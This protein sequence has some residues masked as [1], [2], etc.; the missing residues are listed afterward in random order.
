MDR[1]LGGARTRL[2]GDNRLLEDLLS[3][4][5]DKQRRLSDDMTAAGLAKQAAE[6]AARQAQELL[7]YVQESE[8][9]ERIGFKKKLSQEFQRARAAV[10]TTLD[11]LKRD[12][13]IVEGQGN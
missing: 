5:Q 3:D 6:Q 10:Q 2:Q 12:Q 4:L 1:R 13:N 9:D 8:R 11:D 7:T